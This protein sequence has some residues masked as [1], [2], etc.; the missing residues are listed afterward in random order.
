MAVRETL[1]KFPAA[2]ITVAALL[3]VICGVVIRFE[4]KGPD[5]SKA[6]KGFYSDDDGKTWF[7]DDVTKGSPIDHNGKQAYCAMVYRCPG[8][9]PFVA[10][11]AK[12]SDR[13]LAQAATDGR[14]IAAPMQDMKKPG[15]STWVKPPNIPEGGYPPVPCPAG[16]GNAAV[17]LPTDPDS[18]AD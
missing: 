5:F 13:Q 11:L 15:D 17:V 16:G 8:G 4:A 12:F 2:A 3:V 10:Y 14:T 9:R 18:G 6:G 7:L 1:Q